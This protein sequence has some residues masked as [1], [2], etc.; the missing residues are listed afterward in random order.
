[1]PGQRLPMRQVREVLRL[2]HVCGHSGH[3]IAA[4]VGVSRYTVAEY[5]RRA[6]VVGITWPV[7]AELDDA[8]LERK[9][10]TPPF[11]ST[12]AL[13]PQ[14]EWAA[15]PRRAAPSWRHPAVALGGVS[16]RATG[17]IRL[18]PVLRS[19]CR[20]ARPACRPPCARPIRRVSG[21]SSTMPGRPCE[22]IDGA[23]GEIT[24]GA[25][26]RRGARRLQLH[27]CRGPLDA[28]AAG[29]DRLP[30]GRVRQLRRRRA[31]DRLRQ[32]QGRRHRRHAATSR[33]SAGPTRTW[34]ATT[35]QPSCRPGSVGPATRPKSKSPSRSCSVGCWPGCGTAGSSPWPN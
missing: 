9:L 8:A 27:L 24:A 6:A 21:C 16:G 4:M 34:R 29:L 20:L 11:A 35:A 10:F 22:V 12:E 14:P 7:P 25:D 26:L 1:M 23:T 30:R 33:G 32:S 2:K 28:V 17:G 5:L 15:H 31:A 13:R 3:Q 19:V 18:Q